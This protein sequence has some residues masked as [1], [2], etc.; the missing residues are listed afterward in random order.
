MSLYPDNISRLSSTNDDDSAVRTCKGEFQLPVASPSLMQEMVTMMR[1]SVV[2]YT[3][4]V[5]SVSSA[6]DGAEGA[7]RLLP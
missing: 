6:F 3:Y 4:V 1:I 7:A 5:S 2:A